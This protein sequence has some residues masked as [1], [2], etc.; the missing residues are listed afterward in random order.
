[1]S[2]IEQQIQ[3]AQKKK[4]N[5]ELKLQLATNAGNPDRV[6]AAQYAHITSIDNLQRV[7]YLIGILC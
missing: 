1:M 4:E 3:E 7:L 2:S 5:A 6:K